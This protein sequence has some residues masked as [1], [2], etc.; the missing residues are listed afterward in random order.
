MSGMDMKVNS[1]RRD[2]DGQYSGPYNP[3]AGF[4]KKRSVLTVLP[5]TALGF[6]LPTFVLGIIGGAAF[7]GLLLWIGAYTAFVF[8]IGCKVFTGLIFLFALLDGVPVRL[9]DRLRN[10][11]EIVEAIIDG[12]FATDKKAVAWGPWWYYMDTDS[13][14]KRRIDK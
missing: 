10:G 11:M 7:S 9:I 14:F 12:W 4:N 5:L 13:T 2:S 8:E 3:H 6:C 1:L